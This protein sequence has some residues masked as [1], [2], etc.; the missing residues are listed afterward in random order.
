MTVIAEN[1]YTISG[2]N[3]NF[4][5]GAVLTVDPVVANK[6]VTIKSGIT[7]SPTLT[8]IYRSGKGLKVKLEPPVGVTQTLGAVDFVVINAN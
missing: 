3:L 2:S 4:A 8:D 7:G 5:T 6:Q 1:T